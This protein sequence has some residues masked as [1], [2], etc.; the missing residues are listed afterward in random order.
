M[1][2][3]Q[4]AIEALFAENRK[5]P[6]PPDFKRDALWSDRGIYERAAR[7]FEGFWSEQAERLDWF[8]RWHTV[9]QWDDARK[10]ARWFDGGKLNVAYN[11]LDRHV[12]HGHG[13]QVAFHWEGEPGDTL[14]VTYE[15][16]FQG[17]VPPRQRAEIARRQE[18]R[19]RRDLHGHGAGTAGGDAGLRAHRRDPL[20][21]LRR[22][23][24]RVLRDRIEDG[25]CKVL[26]T[27]DQ[28][29]RRGG[30]I[31][32]K[33]I[34]DDALRCHPERDEAVVVRRVGDPVDGWK[35]E[36]SG[37]TRS[38]RRRAMRARPSR[39]TPKIRSTSLH[40]A[41]RPLS[42]KASCTPRAVTS[43][44]I[45]ATHK[46][47]FDVKEERDVYWCTADIGWVT[48]HSYIVYAPLANRTTSVLFEG[49]PDYPDK[50]RFWA[51]VEKY[52]VT[53]LYTAPTAIRTFMK[54]GTEYPA[55]HD[56][57]SLRLLGSVGE[58]I[59]PE[60]WIWYQRAHRRRQMPDRRHVVA[61][62]DGHDP[63]LTAAGDHRDEAGFGDAAVPRRVRG[64][65]E[66][67]R[68]V[69]AARRRRLPGDHEAVAGDAA[70]ACG[71]ITSDT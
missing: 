41:A 14:R 21:G 54:W 20:G 33:Q 69:G 8:E 68:R 56:M 67:A 60:A 71:A 55:R 28:G 46:Y 62:G 36:T 23:L 32:L 51:V 6:P 44:A 61:D 13:G 7:D 65:R 37:I 3:L 12:A 34:A 45:A 9:L 48:G 22:L 24:R 53:I 15:S 40:R 11:C 19:P 42:P 63:D 2:D 10:S 43:R 31:P 52:K 17:D 59:N 58:P 29:W 18:G 57:T 27:Q 49:T 26:I 5:F 16:A 35:G 70:H 66:R 38:C 47:I 50:D 25:S 64:R 4:Q 39:W 30:K 1:P